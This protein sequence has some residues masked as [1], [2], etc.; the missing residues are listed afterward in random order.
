MS[1]V[2]V[3][4]LVLGFAFSARA[5]ATGGFEESVE[6]EA[7]APRRTLAERI[8]AVTR[9]YF[10]KAGRLELFPAVGMSLNDPFYDHIVLRG[11][12]AY[13]VLES[14]SVGLSADYYLS[15]ASP[16]PVAP[17]QGTQPSINRPVYGARIEV[18]WAPLYGKL[19]LLAE[20]VLHLDTFISLGAGIVG[21]S[22]TQPVV[23][24]SVAIG[25]HLFLDE[26]IALRIEFRDQIF[27]M[28]RL[29]DSGKKSSTQNLLSTS[30]AV[31]FFLPTEVVRESL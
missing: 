10:V 13:H 18:S 30:L 21:P 17:I 12:L 19:S 4:S 25:Q 20:Y 29:P 7:E 5:A 16:V 26:W 14:I 2:V 24:G 23:A 9:R 15:L 28:D 31:C 1:R 22:D 6:I 11:G 3:I 8:P 27:A